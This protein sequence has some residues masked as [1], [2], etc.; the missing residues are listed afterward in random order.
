MSHVHDPFRCP[1][2]VEGCDCPDPADSLCNP[3]RVA[4]YCP[5]D[6]EVM[7]ASRLG[8]P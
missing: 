2:H 8:T 6:L 1:A 3:Y 7:P 5:D 4:G